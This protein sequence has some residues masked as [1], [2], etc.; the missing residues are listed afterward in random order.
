MED[1]VRWA[2]PI[3]ALIALG[4]LFYSLVHERLFL[5]KVG[6]ELRDS[7]GQDIID[8][9]RINILFNSPIFENLMPVKKI[10]SVQMIKLSTCFVLTRL[11]RP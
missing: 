9:L 3:A 4:I 2:E 10:I 1:C 8:L 6:V 11:G 5:V 7:D